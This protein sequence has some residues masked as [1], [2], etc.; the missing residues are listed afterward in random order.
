[1]TKKKSLGAHNPESRTN[2]F[3][4]K[5]WPTTRYFIEN[6]ETGEFYRESNEGLPALFENMETTKE[7]VNTLNWMDWWELN[8]HKYTIKKD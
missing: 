7:L 2:K 6:S 8:K 1:M 3:V 5:E 4:I